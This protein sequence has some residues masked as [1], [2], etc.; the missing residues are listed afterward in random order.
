VIASGN[1]EGRNI[2]HAPKPLAEVAKELK[3]SPDQARATLDESKELLYAA[4]LK[5][6][7]PLRDEKILTAW[8]GLM[9]SAHARGALVLGDEDY[10]K[11]AV[12]AA[13]F[14]LSRMRREGR[15]QRSYKDGDGRHEGYLEDY[16]FFI[17][18]LLDLY[19]TT[20]TLRWLVEAIDLDRVL[21]KSYEDKS[22]GGFFLTSSEQ[23][24][25]LA[26]EKP[27]H[28]GAEPSGNSVQVMNSPPTIGI[29]S[30]QSACLG[31]LGMCWKGRPPRCQK[32]CSH[33]TS[34]CVPPRRW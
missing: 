20:G 18:G 27:S 6:S 5:R 9:I 10:A 22:A 13:D 11:R 17:A 4:R 25:L 32:C 8:N 12:R 30:E 16:A 19:E 24:K 3:V 33:W 15:L 23:E 29:A 26:R 28:D 7:P 2:L 14:V 31:R 34:T 21:E 1:F